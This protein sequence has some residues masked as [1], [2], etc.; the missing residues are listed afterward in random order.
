M[1]LYYPIKPYL[2]NSKTM[3]T[4]VQI[5]FFITKEQCPTYNILYSYV[6]IFYYGTYV[7]TIL[8]FCTVR[9]TNSIITPVP[10]TIILKKMK[11]LV[12]RV[13]MFVCTYV[14]RILKTY[15]LHVPSNTNVYVRYRK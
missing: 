7:H 2:L 14:H 1:T 12:I 9:Y 15:F 4:V 13:N 5:F 6:L 3:R 10:G 11:Y 8:I